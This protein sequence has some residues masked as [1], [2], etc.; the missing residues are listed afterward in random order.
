MS[1]IP[2]LSGIVCVVTSPPYN[3]NIDTFTPSGMHKES[4]WVEKIGAGYAD[5]M[6]EDEY[7]QWQVDILNAL[8]GATTDNGSIFYNHKLR[9]RDQ[10]PIYPSDWIR[11]SRWAIRQEIV[12]ARNGSC[13]MN[14][15]MF[16][17]SCER[18]Y[19]LR[20]SA[21]KW[22][23]S[24]VGYMSVWNIASKTDPDH[25]CAYPDEIPSRCIE[26]TTDEMDVV[27]DPFSGSGTTAT[28]CIRMGRRFVGMEK[29]AKYFAES[30]RRVEQAFADQALFVPRPVEV[31]TE[32]F[33]A[34]HA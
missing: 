21:F 1:V 18:I 14:A 30:V 15:R 12:W 9:Y 32:M 19:W 28:V 25:P 20:K 11:R 24:A 27:C 7:Q 22:N 2:C 5:S 13:T 23:Q 17:P 31:Q 3:Q 8:G 29:S 10:S 16:A 34:D 6:P 4:R 33:G 26:A